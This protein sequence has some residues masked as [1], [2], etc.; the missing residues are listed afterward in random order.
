MKNGERVRGSEGEKVTEREREG[1]GERGSGR[2]RERERER[3]VWNVCWSGGQKANDGKKK[4]KR[5]E[6]RE[7]LT[8]Y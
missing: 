4:R 1:A 7:Q 5:R 3:E 6:E 8:T 2:E